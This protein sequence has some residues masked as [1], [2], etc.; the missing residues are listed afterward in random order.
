MNAEQVGR[1]NFLRATARS[2]QRVLAV[3]I[4]SVRHGPVPFKAHVR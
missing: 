4:L 2:A 1:G 3:V